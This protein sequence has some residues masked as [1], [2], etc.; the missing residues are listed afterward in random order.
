VAG[1]TIVT[2][3][4]RP[5]PFTVPA[6]LPQPGGFTFTIELPPELLPIIRTERIGLDPVVIRQRLGRE[7][8]WWTRLWDRI[9]RRHNWPLYDDEMVTIQFEFMQSDTDPNNYGEDAK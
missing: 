3:W 5:V 9:T 8:G 7:Q 1:Q 4:W 2:G 6:V